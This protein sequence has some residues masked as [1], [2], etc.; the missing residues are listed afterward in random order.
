MES[1]HPLLCRCQQPSLPVCERCIALHRPSLCG[2]I[3][4]SLHAST[5]GQSPG[6]QSDHDFVLHHTT[7]CRIVASGRLCSGA[8]LFLV[9]YTI[10][11]CWS[12][13]ACAMRRAGGLR[14]VCITACCAGCQ[15]LDAQCIDARRRQSVLCPDALGKLKQLVPV[16]EHRCLDRCSTSRAPELMMQGC[17]V[18]AAVVTVR[19]TLL[20]GRSQGH[21]GDCGYSIVADK[22][23]AHCSMAD[24]LLAKI[25]ICCCE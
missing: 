16:Q 1:L 3:T 7:R 22:L 11:C 12:S 14:G 6:L 4:T 13:K 5:N 23:A 2:C 15:L 8:M 25:N 10:Y 20:N 17:V 9:K 21:V 24:A 19:G 18:D